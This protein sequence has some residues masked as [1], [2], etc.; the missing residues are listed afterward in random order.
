MTAM[1]P[2]DVAALFD[3][4]A[5]EPAEPVAAAVDADAE[6]AALAA[7]LEATIAGGGIAG[8]APDSRA[9]Q[10]VKVAWPARMRLSDGR[11]VALRLRDISETGVGLTS[12]EPVPVGAVV[13]L[14]MDVPALAGGPPTKVS[15]VI[16]TGYAV[17]R[18]T[19]ILCGAT[20][21]RRAPADLAVVNGWIQR[22]RG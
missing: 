15:S 20:W 19:E 1:R 4:P 7:E 10:R 17:V 14:E 6:E 5:P 2:E 11:T 3:L 18:G 22:L 9:G 16:K 8:D 12:D 21:E 13:D